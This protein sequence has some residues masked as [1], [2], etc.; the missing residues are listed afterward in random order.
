[1][2]SLGVETALKEKVKIKTMQLRKEL[3]QQWVNGRPDSSLI[4]VF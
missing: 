1:M 3:Q 2:N 4:L